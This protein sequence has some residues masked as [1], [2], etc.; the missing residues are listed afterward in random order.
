[1]AASSSWRR[2]ELTDFPIADM[3]RHVAERGSL[4][5]CAPDLETRLEVTKHLCDRNLIAWNKGLGCYELTS[6]GRD[7]LDEPSRTAVSAS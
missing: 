5:R 2:G 3:L 1:M 6:T 4:L 7:Y